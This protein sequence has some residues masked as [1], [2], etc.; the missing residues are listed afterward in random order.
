M[1]KSIVFYVLTS[2]SGPLLLQGEF[3]RHEEAITFLNSLKDQ[4]GISNARLVSIKDTG[5][6]YVIDAD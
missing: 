3:V 4:K 6:L 1:I 5:E 2:R